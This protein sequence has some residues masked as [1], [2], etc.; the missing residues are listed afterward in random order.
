MGLSYSGSEGD[1]LHYLRSVLPTEVRV[2]ALT[3]PLSG[4]LL[5]ATGFKR[6]N[7]L[8]HLVVQL[9]DGSPGTILAAVTDIWGEPELAGLL[10]VLDVEGLRALRRRVGQLQ[11]TSPAA[12]LGAG[13]RK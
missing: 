3:H 5:V 13:K 7:G 8:L 1:R 6:L 2:V 9:P 10:V 4:Q 11:P 12:V